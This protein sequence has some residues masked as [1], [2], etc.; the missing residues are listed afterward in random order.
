MRRLRLAGFVVLVGT[1]V[2]AATAAG[3]AQSPAGTT[4]GAD[5]RKTVKYPKPEQSSTVLKGDHQYKIV[6]RGTVGYWPVGS[7]EYPDAREGEGA[8]ALYC[9]V[10]W[11]CPKP[12]LWRQLRINGLALDE[13]AGKTGKIPYNASHVYPVTVSGVT[14]KLTYTSA[15]GQSG[16]FTV[17][18]IDL[19]AVTKKPKT[20][21]APPRVPASVRA[22]KECKYRVRFSFE[23]NRKAVTGDLS[24]I[25]SVGTGDFEIYLSAKITTA[26]GKGDVVVRHLHEQITED[27]VRIVFRQT[28]AEENM[29]LRIT[30]RGGKLSSLEVVAGLQVNRSND[31]DCPEFERRTEGHIFIRAGE[32]RPF[33]RF[34]ICNHDELY[35]AP[36]SHVKVR[37]DVKPA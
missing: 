18:V 25:T 6:A 7:S 32:P 12:E 30:R 5:D 8:D 11:R 19:G 9:Y 23:Q 17:E 27:D 3:S 1:L 20:C 24:E 36:R 2:G 4:R 16:G 22:G 35:V 21:P 13:F 26:C 34:N 14:G 37:I 33:V 15:G 31:V 29:C 10:T 28:R